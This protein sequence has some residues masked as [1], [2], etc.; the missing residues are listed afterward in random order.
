MDVVEDD[1]NNAILSKI[2]NKGLLKPQNL[3]PSFTGSSPAGGARRRD[4]SENN[5]LGAGLN[6]KKGMLRNDSFTS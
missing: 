5:Y 2:E 6:E 4:A 1:K 3:K